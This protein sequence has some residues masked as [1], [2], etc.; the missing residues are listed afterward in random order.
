MAR[1][2]HPQLRQGDLRDPPLQRRGDPLVAPLALALD[3]RGVQ[4][5]LEEGVLEDEGA[6]GRATFLIEDLRLGQLA[7]LSLISWSRPVRA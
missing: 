1:S 2:S 3:K 4:G 5:V 7:Q 6:P